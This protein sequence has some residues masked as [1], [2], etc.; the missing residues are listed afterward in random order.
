MNSGHEEALRKFVPLAFSAEPWGLGRLAK[1]M[2][3]PVLRFFRPVPAI[4]VA[5]PRFWATKQVML[6]AMNFMLAAHSAGLATVPMEGFDEGRVK[7]LA[8]IPGGHVVPLIIPV[9]YAKSG[10]LKKSR[11]PLDRIW[12]YE[13]W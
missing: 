9:G 5:D 2:G 7:K 1:M 8:G 3:G 12:H 6:S 10:D 4:P 11:L 13:T